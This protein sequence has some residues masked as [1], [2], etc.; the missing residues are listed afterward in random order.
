MTIGD[1]LMI[2]TTE[3]LVS[4]V[5]ERKTAAQKVSHLELMLGQIAN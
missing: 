2:L 5:N 3:K 4:E 1:L